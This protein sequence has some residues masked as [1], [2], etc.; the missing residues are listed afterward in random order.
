VSSAFFTEE[1]IAEVLAAFPGLTRTEPIGVQG[2]VQLH[3]SFRGR[4]LKD[5]FAIRITPKS[6]YSSY[7]PAL[8]E[9]GGRTRAIARARGVRDLRDLHQNPDD[10][11]ACVCPPQLE[12]VKCPPG[13]GL[14]VFMHELAIPYLYG[15]RYYQD[16]GSWPWGEYG[17]GALGILEC[18]GEL[19]CNSERSELDRLAHVVRGAGPEYKKQMNRPSAKR[20]CPCG[21]GTPFRDCHPPAWKGLKLLVAALAAPDAKGS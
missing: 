21:S 20:A 14:L 6:T 9:T 10:R 3:A 4:E 5:L 2:R 8:F 7:L 11:S 15:L 12:R 13:S 16:N 19:G 1:S 18:Y 17:H